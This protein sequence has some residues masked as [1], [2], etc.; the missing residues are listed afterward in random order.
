MTASARSTIALV[1]CAEHP[2]LSP[3]DRLLA[4][5]LERHGC[6]VD[7]VLWDDPGVRW[8]AYDAVV[9]RSTWDY[10]HRVE[11]FLGW[12]D[13][14]ERRHV[15]VF[16]RIATLRWNVRKTYLRDL[17]RA[18]IPVTPTV[19]VPMGSRTTLREAAAA[20]GAE[21]LVVKPSVSASGYETWRV[22]RRR[23]ADN[24][25][26]FARLLAERDLMIQPFLESVITHGELSL[27]FLAGRY[28]HAVRKR[29]K[30][31]DF[32][33]QEEH[34]GTAAREAVGPDL[35][36]QASRALSLA[37]DPPLYARV[38]GVVLDGTLVITELELVEPMLYFGWDEQAAERLAAGLEQLLERT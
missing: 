36:R 29:A 27:V 14:L 35:L 25:R 24:E 8:E 22:D 18:A 19:W 21:A 12:L 34:G 13:L 4:A 1:T 3:D 7:A 16:N 11:A 32:R 31:G 6:R 20:I 15:H 9:V 37:P 2:A 23:V 30:R 28:S 10:H 5:A 38:D 17:E 26:R 33:V